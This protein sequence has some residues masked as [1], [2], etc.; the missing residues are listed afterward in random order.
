[1]PEGDAG[2]RSKIKDD[3]IRLAA[4]LYLHDGEG[5]FTKRAEAILQGAPME[6]V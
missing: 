4:G 6:L 3:D 5:E 2:S 1:M